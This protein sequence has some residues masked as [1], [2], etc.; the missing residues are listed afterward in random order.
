MHHFDI[1]SLLDKKLIKLSRKNN[2]LYVKVMKKLREVVNSPN[3]NHY[4]NLR[5]PKQEYKRV[6]VGSFVL[7]F[8]YIEDE[9]LIVFSD[10][11]HH[12]YIY[13]W[14]LFFSINSSFKFLF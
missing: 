13:E 3:I 14:F 9:D 1:S 2:Y 7:L 10:F 4:K 5:K 12:D 11:D 6:H 8:K